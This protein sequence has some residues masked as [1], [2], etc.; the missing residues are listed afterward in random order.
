MKIEITNKNNPLIKNLNLTFDIENIYQR[1]KD[2]LQE[3]FLKAK[4]YPSS[5][6]KE[7]LKICDN[8]EKPLFEDEG[9]LDK[10]ILGNYPLELE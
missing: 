7:L 4:M 9:H 8:N 3:V 6:K 1:H 10:M 2:I 5:R